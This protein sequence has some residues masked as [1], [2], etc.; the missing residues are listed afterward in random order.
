MPLRKEHFVR[1]MAPHWRRLRDIASSIGGSAFRLLRRY[2]ASGGTLQRHGPCG[3]RPALGSMPILWKPQ[4][5][6]CYLFQG[7]LTPLCH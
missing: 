1:W 6:V 3:S 4:T 7:R 2:R 5:G